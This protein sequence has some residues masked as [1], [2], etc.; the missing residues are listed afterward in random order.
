M[1][2]SF[3][4][5]HFIKIK[6]EY[7]GGLTDMKGAWKN[8][9][10]CSW[11][12]QSGNGKISP[13]KDDWK[14]ALLLRLTENNPN[15]K[16]KPKCNNFYGKEWVT[17]SCRKYFGRKTLGCLVPVGF[18]K[19]IEKHFKLIFL[20]LVLQLAT[21][22]VAIIVICAKVSRMLK[23]IYMFAPLYTTNRKKQED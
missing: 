7:I 9:W 13:V 20:L 2:I 4:K 8:P 11:S 16:T 5:I 18:G 3:L 10:K 22:W 19:M 23:V 14:L 15:M 21:C 1:Y 6:I 17:I 12:K